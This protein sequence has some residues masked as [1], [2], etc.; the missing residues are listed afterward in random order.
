MSEDL[1]WDVLDRIPDDLLLAA[2]DMDPQPLW[3]WCDALGHPHVKSHG[4]CQTC[5]AGGPCILMMFFDAVMHT[6]VRELDNPSGLPYEDIKLLPWG[7][8]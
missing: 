1:R 5:G 7:E 8:V 3:L 2:D 4:Y 6:T